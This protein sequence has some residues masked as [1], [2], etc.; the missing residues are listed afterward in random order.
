MEKQ[1]LEVCIETYGKDIYSFCVYLTRSRQEAE[2]LYQETFLKAVELGRKIEQ[3]R[4]PKSFLLSVTLHI[5]KNRKRKYGWRQRIAGMQSMEDK[6]SAVWREQSGQTPEDGVLDREERQ[7]VR[8]AVDRL[9]EKMKMAV[10][11]YYMEEIPV[12]QIAA[13]LKVPPGTVMSRLHHARK[14]LKKELEDILY[15]KKTG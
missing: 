8:E 4:N 7:A 13:L 1:E 12:K 11:L 9:P 10:L 5:W 6:D 14:I 2:D 15:G 3:E